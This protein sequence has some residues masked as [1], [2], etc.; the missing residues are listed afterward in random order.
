MTAKNALKVQVMMVGGR[1]CGK[2][3]V[4]AAMKSNFEQRFAETDLTMSYTD[5]ETLSILEEKNS[6][7]EDYF[8]GSEN[9]TFSPDSN[10]T[11]EM[12]TYSLSVGIKDRKD[13][14]QVDFLDYP[15]EWLTDNEH[16][17]LLLETMK[18]SQVLMIA[19]DT[20]HMMEEEGK[21][22]ERRNF[23]HR[24]GEMIKMALEKARPQR[25][26]V[27]FVP[28]KCERYLKD[29]QMDKV[30]ATTMQSY[31][32]LIRYF[33]KDMIRYEVA[34]TPIF[35]LGKAYFSRFER[36]KESGD[37]KINRQFGTPKKAIYCFDDN[38]GKKPEPKYCEQPLVYLLT[39]LMYSSERNKRNKKSILKRNLWDWIIEAMMELFFKYSS[40]EDYKNQKKLLLKKLKKSGEGY[41]IL[42]DP[43]KFDE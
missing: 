26:L 40:P 11:A 13:T 17:E 37:I 36:D 3:S 16:K 38:A 5:L 1:R 42:Q 21:Y 25:M 2:T 41:R 31:E 39:Y 35:T 43:M 22:N 33:K 9:R 10:P 20:P 27:L 6:E 8:L 19:I 24:T 34:V 28:L 7:I 32:E 23:C 30:L 12:V 14:M 29:N 4:L 15:G 18:K